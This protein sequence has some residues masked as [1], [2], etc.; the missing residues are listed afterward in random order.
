MRR[1]RSGAP[2]A[3]QVISE[4]SSKTFWDPDMKVDFRSDNGAGRRT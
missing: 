4:T 2:L 3:I 1:F